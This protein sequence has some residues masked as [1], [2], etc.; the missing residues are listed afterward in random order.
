MESCNEIFAEVSSLPA[1]VPNSL[2]ESGDEVA[3]LLVESPDVDA[4][5]YTG[6]TRVGRLIMAEGAKQLKRISLAHGVPA[7][8][9]P[10][11]HLQRPVLHDRQPH[12]GPAVDRRGAS[13]TP[14]Q[15]DLRG[16][17]RP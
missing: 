16:Q 5:S 7:A 2:T 17:G 10:G 4:L 13:G 6:S 1:G 8:G 12:P 14:E 9:R 15:V 3:R 11:H